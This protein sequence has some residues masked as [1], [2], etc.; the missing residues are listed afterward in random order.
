MTESC[1]YFQVLLSIFA[2]SAIF[3]LRVSKVF[4]IL[5]ND[6]RREKM[7]FVTALVGVQLMCVR[8]RR[9]S[10]AEF[11]S[12]FARQVYAR[13][14]SENQKPEVKNHRRKLGMPE[15]KGGREGGGF[16]VLSLIKIKNVGN[17]QTRKP[18]AFTSPPRHAYTLFKYM[19]EF[20]NKRRAPIQRNCRK[21][22]TPCR[23]GKEIYGFLS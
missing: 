1:E 4:P 17:N 11:N 23:Q 20:N 12:T 15:I 9:I 7:I 8:T 14:N 5:I 19:N 16:N 13:S 10:S 3:A 6:L 2:F 21:L 18:G 22:L